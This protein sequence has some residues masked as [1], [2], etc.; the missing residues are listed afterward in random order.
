MSNYPDDIN[1]DSNDPRSP[2]YDDGGRE[3]AEHDLREEI[4]SGDC[5]GD[6]TGMF[7]SSDSDDVIA[8]LRDFHYS[9]SEAAGKQLIAQLDNML[10]NLIQSKLEDM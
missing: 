9:Q 2:L 8:L 1:N 7:D 10:E 6:Y 3:D 5:I 4:L